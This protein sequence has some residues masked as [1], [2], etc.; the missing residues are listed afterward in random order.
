MFID[1]NS[2]HLIGKCI[3]SDELLKKIFLQKWYFYCSNDYNNFNIVDYTNSYVLDDKS[4]V[5][6]WE[7]RKIIQ[8]QCKLNLLW[9]D[10]CNPKKR[11]KSKIWLFNRLLSSI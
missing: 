3:F 10:M 11:Q 6:E 9:Y 7:F 2:W 4:N 5:Y 8:F 1:E